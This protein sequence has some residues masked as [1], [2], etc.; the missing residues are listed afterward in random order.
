MPAD[1][2][3][4][5]GTAVESSWR[6]RDYDE[7]AFPE[8][9]QEALAARP[10]AD[11]VDPVELAASFL[12]PDRCPWPDQR[13]S[14]FGQPPLIVFQGPR[15]H[16][17]VLC[18]LDG[19]T[20][21]HQHGF[22]GAFHVLGGSSVH[23]LYAFRE[24]RRINTSLLLG[25]L[26]LQRVEL[27]QKGDTRPIRSGASCIHGLFHLETPSFT[28]VVRTTGD[29]D[30]HPQYDYLKPHVAE[31]HATR[32]RLLATRDRLWQLLAAAD[33]ETC[34]RTAVDFVRTAD[35]QSAWH[36]LGAAHRLWGDGPE[37]QD[38]LAAMREAHGPDV[39]LLPRVLEQRWWSEHLTG[40]RR[41]VS[42]P[43]LRFFLALL[44]NVPDRQ[45][46]RRCV[47]ERY[48]GEPQPRIL[49]WVR[50][51]T[52]ERGTL[53][54]MGLGVPGVTAEEFLA[55]L[56]DLLDGRTPDRHGTVTAGL[57]RSPLRPLVA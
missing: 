20:T 18:W 12:R 56:G 15:F 28:V 37:F 22:S 2:F 29:L 9:A 27:L 54:V 5:L 16:V 35:F 33:A 19:T 32:D 1:F 57:A 3:H 24:R 7:R 51:L 14:D 10:P 48:G 47:Q 53:T 6:R 8:V 11:A 31:D 38:V 49:D 34:R 36:A 23:S 50:R 26:E 52:H 17:E 41:T 55:L 25:D 46:L 30:A 39:D 4:A 43:D 45:N 13:P 42:D 44:L 21:L 40:L